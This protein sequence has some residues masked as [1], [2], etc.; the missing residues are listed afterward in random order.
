VP[1]LFIRC[2]EH[3]PLGARPPS[4]PDSSFHRIWREEPGKQRSGGPAPCIRRS[5]PMPPPHKRIING[6]TILHKAAR[7][8]SESESAIRFQLKRCHRRFYHSVNDRVPPMPAPSFCLRR[9][10]S[11]LQRRRWIGER[12]RAALGRG[13]SRALIDADRSITDQA[14]PEIDG[15]HPFSHTKKK[16]THNI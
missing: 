13:H 16:S 10:R 8:I 14:M 5:H 9:N 2:T 11:A 1:L 3:A 15:M 7:F 12:V 6:S 4:P